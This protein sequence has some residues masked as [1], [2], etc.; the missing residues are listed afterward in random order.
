[1]F[2]GIPHPRS[3]RYFNAM[4]IIDTTLKIGI[5]APFSVI[6][7]SDTHLCRADGRDDERKLKLAEGRRKYFPGAE[8]AL[9]DA[10]R[11]VNDEGLTVVHTGDLIDFV[12]E[13]NIDAAREFCRSVDC[14]FA[15]GNHEFSLYVGEAFEDEAYRNISLAKVQAAFGNDIRFSSRVINGVN[16]VAVDDSYYRFDEAQLEAL[17][18]EAERGLP[19]VLFMHNPLYEPYLHD[20]MIYE[21]HSEC[22]YLTG[23]PKSLLEGYS[24]YRFRQQCPDDITLRTIEYIETQP[25]I[26]AIFSGHLHFSYDGQI[27]EALAQYVTGGAGESVVRRIRFE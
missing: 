11:L 8:E 14:F 19:I 20:C 12:S 22:A 24:D 9:V 21:R 13:A 18:R 25:L 7:M 23:T 15:A 27:S 17:K 2:R 1:M 4:K 10:V 26:K 5:S 6:H 3:T 16:L